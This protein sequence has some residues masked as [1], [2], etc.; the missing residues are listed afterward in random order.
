MQFCR[1]DLQKIIM[2]EKELL[3]YLM[4][5]HVSVDPRPT[6]LKQVPPKIYKVIAVAV[7]PQ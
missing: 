4:V 1:S 6:D 7:D 2:A 5:R 3:E